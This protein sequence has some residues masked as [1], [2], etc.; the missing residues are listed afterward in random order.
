MS[1]I[2]NNGTR[3]TADVRV[4]ANSCASTLRY[5]QGRDDFSFLKSSRVR[6]GFY[7]GQVTLEVGYSRRFYM[8]LFLVGV[9][10]RTFV[11]PGMMIL[12]S[13]KIIST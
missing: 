9:G 3:T 2:A 11:P 12:L 10:G 6:L 8:C 5:H 1:F 13:T 7:D 4:L